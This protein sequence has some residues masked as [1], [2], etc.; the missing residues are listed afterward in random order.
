MPGLLPCFAILARHG[1][2]AVL[3]RV[4][5]TPSRTLNCMSDLIY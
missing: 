2:A 4:R 3:R 1:A 5:S